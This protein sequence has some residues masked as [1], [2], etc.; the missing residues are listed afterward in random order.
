MNSKVV[1]T[2]KIEKD[3]ALKIAELFMKEIGLERHAKGIN[4]VD[5]DTNVALKIINKFLIYP[6][7]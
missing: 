2:E 6:R 7:I 5:Q 4:I 1:D 3:T